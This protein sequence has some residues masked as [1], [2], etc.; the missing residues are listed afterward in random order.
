METKANHVWVG[1]VTLS[2]LAALA[3]F[4]VWIARWNEEGRNSYDIFFK[5][6]VDGLSAGSSVSFQGVPIG[7]IEEIEL[8]P[9]DPS[10]V[11]VRIGVDEKVPILLGTTATIQSSFTGT[12]NIQL[13]GAVRDA[14]PITEKGPEGVPVIPTKQGGLGALLNTAPVLLDRLATASERLNIALSDKNLES[15]ENILA[16]TDRMTGN[17]A[18]ASPEVQRTLTDLQATLKQATLTL[19]EFENVARSADQFLSADGQ[20]L[21][22]DLRATLKSASAAAKELEATLSSARPAAERLNDQTLPQ[23]EAAIRDLRATSKA[24]R[25]LTEKLDDGGA[26]ALLGGNKLPEYK[27]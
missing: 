6:S 12:S 3:A 26:G 1:V 25:D 11:R 24:L 9:K 15:I 7:Q 5:Q 10:F 21:S 19:T 27:P 4:I 16:N 23:A 20:A 2:L 17:L 13:Q 18:N 8:W 14:P 22:K